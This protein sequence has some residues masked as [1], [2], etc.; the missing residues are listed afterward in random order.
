MRWRQ[1]SWSIC[2]LIDCDGN[3]GVP[4]A[5]PLQMVLR[6][7]D[8]VEALEAEKLELLARLGDLPKTEEGAGFGAPNVLSNGA[9]PQ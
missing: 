5:A 1:E 2:P 7:E 8:Q 6:L 4:H 3:L 9:G